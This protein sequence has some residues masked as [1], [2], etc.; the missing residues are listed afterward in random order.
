MKPTHRLAFAIAAATLALGNTTVFADPRD[1][2]PPGGDPQG[3]YS[4]YDHQG[5][6]DRDGHY[7]YLDNRPRYDDR[8][9][10]YQPPPSYYREGDY[11]RG[12]QSGNAA[13][14]TIFGAIA[15]GL[16]GG[17]ASHGNG[18]AV[19]GGVLLGGLLGNTIARDIPCEDHRYAFRAYAEGLNGRVGER[20]EWRNEDNDDYGAFTPTREFRRG[21]YTCKEFH[22]V[23]YRG[24]NKY[25]RHG[26]ACRYPDGNWHFDD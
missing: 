11:E 14:G 25:E 22:E 2:P 16:I 15:G 10:G 7:R 21:D 5:Y 23:S 24:G 9:Q 4:D 19:V 3:Y 20:Y 6:Y 13:A 18:G 12:C 1:W 17:A 8:D 26:S